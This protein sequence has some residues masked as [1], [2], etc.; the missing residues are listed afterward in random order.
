[1][2]DYG[3]AGMDWVW[4]EAQ[5][6]AVGWAA[7]AHAMRTANMM[8]IPALIRT[9]THDGGTIERLLDTGAEGLIAPNVETPEQAREIVSH[10]YYPPIGIRS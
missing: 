6:N 3:V 4:W 5:H 8:E 7:T 2:L 9:W 1:M 10:C